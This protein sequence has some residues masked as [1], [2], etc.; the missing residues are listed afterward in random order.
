MSYVDSTGRFETFRVIRHERPGAHPGR[1]HVL[2]GCD[3][4]GPA[5]LIEA[6]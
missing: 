1:A 2:R 3:F 6:T 5:H 4:A